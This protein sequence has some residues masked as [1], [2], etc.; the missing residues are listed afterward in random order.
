MEQVFV[1]R[2]NVKSNSERAARIDLANES[3]KY[4]ISIFA[5]S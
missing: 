4:T 1:V 5:V 3:V 2:A